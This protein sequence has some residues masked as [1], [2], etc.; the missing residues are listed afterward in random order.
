M[1]DVDKREVDFLVTIDG[2]PWFAV[3]AKL[4]DK[5]LSPHLLYFKERF[6]IPYVYQVVKTENIDRF[7]KACEDHLS[8]E[9]P[10][11]ADLNPYC[12]LEN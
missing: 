1:R 7:S 10:L 4:S 11:G 9:I 3:E 2:E 5:N 6:A 12:C 8:I